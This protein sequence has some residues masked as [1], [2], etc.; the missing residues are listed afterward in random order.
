MAIEV[1][2][3]KLSPT[4]ETGTINRW[5]KK[6]GETVSSGDTVAEVETDKATMPLEV[7][8]DGTLLKIIAG[9]GQTVKVDELIAVVGQKGEDISKMVA[10]ASTAWAAAIPAAAPA[11]AAAP[12]PAKAEAAKAAPPPPPPPVA[13]ATAV[14]APP[15]TDGVHQNGGRV[16]ASPLAK[17]LA[18]ERGIDLHGVTPSGPGGRIIER[19]VPQ[20]APAAGRV[21]A[22]P[23]A[24]AIPSFPPSAGVDIPLSNLRQTIARRL[25]QS[26]QQLPHWYLH[27]EINVDRLMQLREELNTKSEETGIKISVNDLIL[28]VAAA[29]L[30]RHPEVNATFNQTSIHRHGDVNIA[31]AVATE[32]GLYTP[33]LRNVDRLS[34]SQISAGVK[35][36]AK[37][38]REKKLKADD[39][40]GSGFTI[41]NLGMYGIDHFFAIINPPE[42]A[43]LAVGAVKNK[44]IVN[45][46]GQVVAGKVMGLTLSSD[47]RVIDGAVGAQFMGTLQDLLEHPAKLLL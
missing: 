13:T 8:E 9:E 17:K 10:S 39:L 31:V 25:L 33:V 3:A 47:H 16:K 1:R 28:K 14:A 43:I 20:T 46:A 23:A 6:E 11:K 12:A 35:E 22:V 41:S 32:D 40:T 37:K 4:M 42:A 44:P 5:V 45:A 27:S 15:P 18:Q 36:L 2:M 24:V 38:T 26:K 30:R 29:A 34:L 21:P 7:F 19:D